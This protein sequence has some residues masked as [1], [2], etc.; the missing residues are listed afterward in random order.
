MFSKTPMSTSAVKE[1]HCVVSNFTSHE[2]RC[3]SIR[4]PNELQRIIFDYFLDPS[5]ILK[6]WIC[7]WK[8]R[9]EKFNENPDYSCELFKTLTKIGWSLCWEVC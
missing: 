6:F 9:I 8:N 2:T 7:F 4:M 5:G 1:L 3:Y